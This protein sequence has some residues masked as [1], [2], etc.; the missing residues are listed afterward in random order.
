MGYSFVYPDGAFYLMVKSPIADATEF[1]YA[2]ANKYHLLLV[3]TD[4][5]GYPGYV[6]LSYCVSTDMIK[7]SLPAFRQLAEE[8]GIC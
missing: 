3:P 5:F 6:R 7:R 2:A 4:D 1:A 8:Y